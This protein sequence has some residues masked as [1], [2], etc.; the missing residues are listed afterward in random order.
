M[1]TR[2]ELARIIRQR[3]PDGQAPWGTNK[4]LAHGRILYTSGRCRCD[5]CRH[6]NNAYQREYRALRKRS[7]S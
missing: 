2:K 7:A 4:A 6:D 3:F 5:V 1:T